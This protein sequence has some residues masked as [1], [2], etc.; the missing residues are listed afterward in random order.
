[1][2]D[3]NDLDITSDLKFYSNPTVN[4]SFDCYGFMIGT[5]YAS[6]KNVLIFAQDQI[7]TKQ[8]IIEMEKKWKLFGEFKDFGDVC[9]V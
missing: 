2:D 3:N 5:K 9:K 6:V 7:R 8:D 1:M 4:F